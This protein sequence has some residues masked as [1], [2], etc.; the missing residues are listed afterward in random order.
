MDQALTVP[1]LEGHTINKEFQ[2]RE[3]QQSSENH[4]HDATNLLLVFPWASLH[5]VLGGARLPPA[6]PPL[7]FCQ[8]LRRGEEVWW[9]SSARCNVQTERWDGLCG[10]KGGWLVLSSQAELYG[11]HSRAAHQQCWEFAVL[12]GECGPSS[13][14]EA[15]PYAHSQLK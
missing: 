3:V 15:L 5:A 7:S 6:V 1:G 8:A 11:T 9:R 12:G 13:Q 10:F 2:S 4:L 14:D